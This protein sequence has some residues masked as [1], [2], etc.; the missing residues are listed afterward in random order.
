MELIAELGQAVIETPRLL[1]REINPHVLK[2]LFSSYPD[3]QIMQQLGLVTTEELATER[4]NFEQGVVTFKTSFKRF[5]MIEKESGKVVG[6]C[7][8]HTWY[9]LH[10]RAEMGY[11]I[12]DEAMK[13]LG[14]MTEAIRALVK[15]GFEEMKLNRIEAFVGKENVPSLRLVRGM[16]FTEEGTLRSHY[17]K[18]GRMEDSICFSLLKDEYCGG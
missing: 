7:G 4:S 1:L 11:A 5:V 16:G 10:S 14:Y 18:N 12:T 17:F 15:Y 3:E 8:F 2:T 9:I 13:G 6:K